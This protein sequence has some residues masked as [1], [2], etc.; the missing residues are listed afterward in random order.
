MLTTAVIV[1]IVL[2]FFTKP[3]QY[4]PVATLASVVFLIG[5]ELIDVSG[6]RRVWAARRDEFLIAAVTAAVV[7]GV[8]VEQAIVTAIIFSIIDHVRRSYHPNDSV[9]V[10][11]ASGHPKATRAVPGA[12]TEPGLV[13]YHF[14]ASLYYANANRLNEEILQLVDDAE[15]KVR[16]FVLDGGAVSDIDYSGGETLKQVHSELEARDVRLL[17]A[18]ASPEVREQLDRYGVTDRIGVD[19]YFETGGDAVDAFRALPAGDTA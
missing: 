7:V 17:I 5:V 3:L 6:M 14:A 13:V 2:L 4:M 18:E 8:G 10:P 9:I 16:W 1:G 19:A 11:G 12:Q 15:P